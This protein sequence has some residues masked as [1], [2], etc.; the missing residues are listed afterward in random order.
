MVLSFLRGSFEISQETLLN[1]GTTS[2]LSMLLAPLL[3]LFINWLAKV[4]DYK[5]RY[6]GLNLRRTW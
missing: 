6:E 1:I 3:F 4:S 5:I 2:L